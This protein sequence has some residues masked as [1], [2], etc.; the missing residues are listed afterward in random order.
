MEKPHEAY[1]GLVTALWFTD[2]EGSWHVV[3]ITSHGGSS[4]YALGQAES[5]ALSQTRSSTSGPSIATFSYICP[6]NHLEE[7]R[8]FI[9][10]TKIF[11]RQAVSTTHPLNATI[12]HATALGYPRLH[13]DRYFFISTN[14][15]S[16]G[17]DP[18]HKIL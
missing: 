16:N 11:S 2:D 1:S 7:L 12:Y 13:E 5:L 14:L 9:K 6:Y 18:T 17:G 4:A 10:R 3:L 8:I 15:G